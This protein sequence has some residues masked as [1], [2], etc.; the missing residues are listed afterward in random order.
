VGLVHT[1]VGAVL[2]PNLPGGWSTVA[3]SDPGIPDPRGCGI[4]M[5][6]RLM[7]SF[8]RRAWYS[9]IRLPMCLCSPPSFPDSAH[10]EPPLPGS[11]RMNPPTS[12][13]RAHKIHLRRAALAA[14]NKY[15]ADNVDGV[16]KS[17]TDTRATARAAALTLASLGNGPAGPEET[18]DDSFAPHNTAFMA[19]QSPKYAGAAATRPSTRGKG[20]RPAAAAVASSVAKKVGRWT[21]SP[22]A[23]FMASATAV[24]GSASGT[25]AVAI[26]PRPAMSSGP[27]GLVGSPAP[28]EPAGPLGEPSPAVN[29]SYTV[30]GTLDLSGV[31]DGVPSPATRSAARPPSPSAPGPRRPAARRAPTRRSQMASGPARP[32]VLGVRRRAQKVQTHR[33][34]AQM[35]GPDTA[36][37]RRAAVLAATSV[38]RGPTASAGIATTQYLDGRSGGLTPLPRPSPP[39]SPTARAGGSVAAA[40]SS[41]AGGGR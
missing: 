21:Q 23:V 33:V 8:S 37:A 9:R 24:A 20:K 19:T 5:R 36:M 12:S 38:L 16:D 10:P 7:S 14:R 22:P 1:V 11:S 39:P 35:T 4:S 3:P 26:P 29:E 41:A 25:A 32:V 17:P 40:P 28:G 15:K 30:A 6:A 2:G 13:D 31:P 18:D 34:T 27:S